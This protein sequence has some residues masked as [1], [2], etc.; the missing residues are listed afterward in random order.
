ML[1]PD[2]ITGRKEIIL[3]KCARVAANAFARD[4]SRQR[5]RAKIGGARIRAAKKAL[6]IFELHIENSPVP[7]SRDSRTAP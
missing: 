4:L 7:N 3:P 6:A 1:T 5:L 2:E